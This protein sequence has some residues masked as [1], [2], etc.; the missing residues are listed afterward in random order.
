MTGQIE[1]A[2]AAAS[3]PSAPRR[4]TFVNVCLILLVGCCLCASLAAS[5]F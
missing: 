4:S 5:L 3:A 2:H 1:T